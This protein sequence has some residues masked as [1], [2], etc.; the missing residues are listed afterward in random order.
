MPEKD[1]ARIDATM[2]N[3]VELTREQNTTLHIILS[4][5]IIAAITAIKAM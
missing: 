4:S 5:F 3:L 1:I 2:K